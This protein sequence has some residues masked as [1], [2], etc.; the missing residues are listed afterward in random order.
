MKI[1]IL[2]LK[3]FIEKFKKIPLKH[4]IKKVVF[5]QVL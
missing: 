1:N 4:G 5:A 2:K 3:L